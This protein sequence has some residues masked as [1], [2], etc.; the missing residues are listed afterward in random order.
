VNN[1]LEDNKTNLSQRSF[2]FSWLPAWLLTRQNG[3][4]ILLGWTAGC[5]DAIGYLGLGRVFTAN[6]TGNTVLLGIALGQG[7]FQELLRAAIALLGFVVGVAGGTIVVTGRLMANENSNRNRPSSQSWPFSI[8]VALAL[9]G[10]ILIIFGVAWYLAGSDLNSPGKHALIML[11]A[12]AM[13]IQ[14]AAVQHLRIT[15]IST[16]YVTGTITS[17]ISELV[18]RFKGTRQKATRHSA[19]LPKVT[20]PPAQAGKSNLRLK[21]SLWFTYTLAAVASSLAMIWWQGLSILLPLIA[22]GFVVLS[23]LSKDSV[24]LA[25][26]EG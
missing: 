24:I 8:S 11:L 19:A 17:F 14:S 2:R 3:S 6:M 1:V 15:G 7:Q 4:I 16:T 21:A 12:I 25:N 26:E 22:L 5:V 10:L 9:E 23:H 13:G 20:I 18:E